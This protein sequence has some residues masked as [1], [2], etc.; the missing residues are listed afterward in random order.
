MF[1]RI[2][3][4]H[5]YSNIHLFNGVIVELHCKLYANL[6]EFSFISRY[7]TTVRVSAV[8]IK[9]SNTIC[10]LIRLNILHMSNSEGRIETEW[11]SP[12]TTV[13]CCSWNVDTA[14]IAAIR[15]KPLLNFLARKLFFLGWHQNGFH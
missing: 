2:K 7:Q 8:Q 13:S 14:I 3:L 6:Y 5:F 10:L 12:E 4:S 9:V 15:W 1:L 11:E